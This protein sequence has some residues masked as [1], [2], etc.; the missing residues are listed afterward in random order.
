MLTNWNTW[1]PILDVLEAHGEKRTHDDAIKIAMEH[2]KATGG[3]R[4]VDKIAN[5]LF[6][7][8]IGVAAGEMQMSILKSGVSGK[9]NSFKRFIA[10]GTSR[11]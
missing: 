8:L 9:S 5:E 10:K 4:R 7:I 2:K 1:G 11:T 3:K 6:R